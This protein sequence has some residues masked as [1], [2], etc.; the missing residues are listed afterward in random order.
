MSLSRQRA[1]P[2]QCIVTA[3]LGRTVRS[4]ARHDRSRRRPDRAERGSMVELVSSAA[5]SPGAFIPNRLNILIAITDNYSDIRFVNRASS[6]CH[7]VRV[8]VL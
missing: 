3:M 1:Q 5:T 6:R 2:A 8:V 7:S 4:R